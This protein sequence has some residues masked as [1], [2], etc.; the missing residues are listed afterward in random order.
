MGVLIGEGVAVMGVVMGAVTGEMRGG[1]EAG[2][3]VNV[4]INSSC[5]AFLL[6]TNGDATAVTGVMGRCGNTGA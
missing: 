4:L 1:A 5:T 3:W 2:L 6:S